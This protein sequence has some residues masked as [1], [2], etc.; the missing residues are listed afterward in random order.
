MRRTACARGPQGQC[1]RG[2]MALSQA[3]LAKKAPGNLR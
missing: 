2:N 3:R 1:D